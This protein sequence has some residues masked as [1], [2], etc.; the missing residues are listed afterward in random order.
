MHQGKASYFYY[1]RKFASYN[2]TIYDNAKKLGYY[3]TWNESEAKRYA[4][5]IA[6]CLFKFMGLMKKKDVS[7]LD[8]YSDNCGGQNRNRFIFAM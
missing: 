6:T 7:E 1:K 2:F 4:N 3:F 5:E 8:F